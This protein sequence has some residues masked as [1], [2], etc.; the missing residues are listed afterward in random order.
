M[1]KILLYLENINNFKIKNFRIIQKKKLYPGMN[2]IQIRTG[3]ELTLLHVNSFLTCPAKWHYSVDGN[4]SEWKV[5]IMASVCCFIFEIW[6]NEKFYC[7]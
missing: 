1:H 7:Q 5:T 2:I 6:H 4:T 3:N